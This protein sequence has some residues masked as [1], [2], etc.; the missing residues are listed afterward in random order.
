MKKVAFL[1]VLI[2]PLIGFGCGFEENGTEKTLQGAEGVKGEVK[3]GDFIFRLVTER[4]QYMEGEAIRLYGELEYIGKGQEI[5]IFHAASPF[6]FP[7]EEKSREFVID[8]PMEQPLLQT[9]VK[10]GEPLKEEYRGS[11]AFG[12]E[13]SEE[14]I[15]FVQRIIRGNF[16]EGDYVVKGSANFYVEEGGRR[17]DYHL[18]TEVEFEVLSRSN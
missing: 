16:P 4:G 2:F 17:T 8:Y 18:K 5:I 10:K 9:I 12:R 11:G 1:I 3:E 6:S 13:D 15:D 14:Y 7:M